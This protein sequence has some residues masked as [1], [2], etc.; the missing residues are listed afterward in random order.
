MSWQIEAQCCE[1]QEVALLREPGS[2]AIDLKLKEI[3]L[4]FPLFF[5]PNSVIN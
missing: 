4:S 3:S 1:E 5:L 2:A